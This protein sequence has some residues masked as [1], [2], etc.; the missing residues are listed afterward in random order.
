MVSM[1]DFP[2]GRSLYISI[3]L[4]SGIVSSLEAP[5]F[6]GYSA[7]R[8]AAGCGLFLF[9]ELLSGETAWG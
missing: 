7:L 6:A 5:S 9:E 3:F 4:K 1:L 2:D 8:F